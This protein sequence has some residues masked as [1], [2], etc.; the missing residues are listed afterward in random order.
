MKGD[1]ERCLG[2]GTAPNFAMLVY[3]LRVHLILVE[4]GYVHTS[5]QMTFLQA[6]NSITESEVKITV[7]MG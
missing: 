1:T 4:K 7:S 3:K 2:S 6:I 5:N